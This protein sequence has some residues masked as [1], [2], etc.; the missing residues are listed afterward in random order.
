MPRLHVAYPFFLICR[1]FMLNSGNL[2]SNAPIIGDY[3]NTKTKGAATGLFY[4]CASFASV[5]C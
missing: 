1:A 2:F 4:F 3:V 5:F